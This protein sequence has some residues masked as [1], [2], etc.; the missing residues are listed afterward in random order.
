MANTYETYEAA[1]IIDSAIVFMHNCLV[2]I[3]IEWEFHLFADFLALTLTLSLCIWIYLDM[4]VRMSFDLLWWPTMYC[5]AMHNWAHNANTGIVHEVKDHK[6][7]QM[8]YLFIEILWC[9]SADTNGQ[10]IQYAIESL[11]RGHFFRF[12]FHGWLFHLPKTISWINAVPTNYVHSLQV[13]MQTGVGEHRNGKG[14]L[15]E[16]KVVPSW[17]LNI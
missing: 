9:R 6:M 12:Y 15:A 8:K 17:I 2:H 16:L 10:I 11:Y 5:V 4:F 3:K 1:G 14:D 7:D 13:P